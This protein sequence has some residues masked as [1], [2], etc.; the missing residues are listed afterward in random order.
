MMIRQRILVTC[1]ITLLAFFL[2]VARLGYV[3]M[4]T[5]QKAIVSEYIDFSPI[6]SNVVDRHGAILATDLKTA[7]IYANP[8]EV[9]DPREVV[10]KV[11]G[12]F[13]DIDQKM[14]LQRLKNGKNFAWIFRHVS[15]KLQQKF[16]GLGLPGVYLQPD[17]KRTY[18][19][20]EIVSHVLGYSDIDNIGLAGVEKFFDTHLNEDKNP[21]QLSIDIRVQYAVHNILTKGLKYF[22]AV[23][24]NVIILDV[25]TG[26]IIAIV[27][28][29][30]F[31]PN[32]IGRTPEATRFNRNTMGLYEPGST[33]KIANIA[34][35]LETGSALI[36]TVFDATHPVKIG[37]F[38]VSDFRGQKRPLTLQESF[39]YSSNIAA[40]KIAQCF[41]PKIQRKVLMNLGVSEKVNLEVFELATPRPPKNWNDVASWT[42]AYGYGIALSP[43]HMIKLVTTIINDG[44]PCHPTLLHQNHVKDQHFKKPIL[45]TKTSRQV[46]DLMRLV[47]TTGTGRKANVCGYR[48]FGKTGTAYQSIG[49]KGYGAIKKRTTSFIGGWPVEQPRYMMILML[50]DP[51]PTPDSHGFATAGH[52][53]AALA[54]EI[55]E[56]VAPMLE[57]LPLSEEVERPDIQQLGSPTIVAQISGTQA[58]RTKATTVR[59]SV[60]L[61]VIR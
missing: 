37:R 14:M 38:T 35:A 18:P 50:D 44:I 36:N 7:S 29:P 52:N 26:E 46:R 40:I 39:L 17:H 23:A 54:G 10:Q 27:S 45:S 2:L 53:A 43:M 11:G 47:V 1:A 51:K 55:I 32:H 5:K 34:I 57:V 9:L 25:K 3:V 61:T 28:L 41:G 56:T 21:L 4:G 13:P 48:V 15:P 8:K 30:T 33:M 6:K 58:A 22:R 60:P 19:H 16:H 49:R 12:I 24:G 20:G 31:N 42:I 59:V